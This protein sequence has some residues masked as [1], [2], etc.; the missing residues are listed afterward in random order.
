[1]KKIMMV[2]VMT[3]MMGL[4]TGCGNKAK[5]AESINLRDKMDENAIAAVYAH[6]RF[7][8]AY[9]EY[10][11]EI[12]VSQVRIADTEYYGE[13]GAIDCEIAVKKIGSEDLVEC[14]DVR[15]AVSS[16]TNDMV[17][18]YAKMLTGGR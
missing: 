12:E 7:E 18:S 5:A 6:H 13:E 2:M 4:M 15:F 14:V 9:S 1:M 17:E 16:I 10:G 11:Y 8:Y 3:L